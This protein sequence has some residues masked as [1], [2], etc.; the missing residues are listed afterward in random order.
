MVKKQNCVIQ[1]QIQLHLYIKRGDVYEDIAE[2]VKTRFDTAYDTSNYE[3]E[4]HSNE[5]PQP[6]EI[7]K[8]QLG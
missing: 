1:I 8:K 4:C 2:D 7:M 5:K 3:L 6:N